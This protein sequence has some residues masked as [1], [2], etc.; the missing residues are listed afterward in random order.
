[1]VIYYSNDFCVGFKIMLDGEF[2]V[3]EVS[4]FVKSGKGQVFVCVKLCCLLIGI[5]VEKIFKFIDF[6]EGV[7]VVDMNLIY[8]YNDGEFWYFMNN[9]IF[10][11]LFVDVKVIGDNVKWLLDQVECIVILWNGQLI[12]VILLNFVELEIIEID[13]GLKGDIVGIGGKLVILF[14]GVVVK[15]L[16]FVQIG[17]VIKVDICFGEYVFCVK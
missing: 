3:V 2:Y 16:L 14:I 12:V 6:V 11:Q 7:D 15:V 9:E 4:E 8:L 10:E 1:M 13:S 5:C 17:E